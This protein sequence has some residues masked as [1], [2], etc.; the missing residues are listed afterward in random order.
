MATSFT[1]YANDRAVFFSQQWSGI[2]LRRSASE[3]G[4]AAE[5]SCT[6]AGFQAVPP[7]KNA[8]LS[9]PDLYGVG[10]GGRPWEKVRSRCHP[11]QASRST[12]GPPRVRRA[13][14]GATDAR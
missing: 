8:S 11:Q 1:R 10:A 2:A 5:R 9:I 6:N 13:H 14:G 7:A 3:N 4:G 12:N